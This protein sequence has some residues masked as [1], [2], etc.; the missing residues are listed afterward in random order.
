MN[1]SYN[2]GDRLAVSNTQKNAREGV[3]LHTSFICK[4]LAC[5]DLSYYVET[6]D[7]GCYTT[8]YKQFIIVDK[9]NH[10]I[11]IN[12]VPEETFSRPVSPEKKSW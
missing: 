10:I 12:N 11:C 6:L 4:V 8:F 3:S 5:N 7:E 1:K 9:D 2:V